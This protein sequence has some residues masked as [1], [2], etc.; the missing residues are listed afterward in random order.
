MGDSLKRAGLL[1]ILPILAA[2]AFGCES[3]S[4][5]KAERTSASMAAAGADARGPAGGYNVP[6]QTSAEVAA[7]LRATCEQAQKEGR[8]LLVEFSAP[9]CADC[10]ELAKM[11]E[12]SG[13][14]EKL[15]HT[16]H[17]VV[18]VGHFDRHE[19]LLKAY[20]IEAIANWQVVEAKDC[21]SPAGTWTKV[22]HRTLEPRSGSKI[23]SEELADWLTAQIP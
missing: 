15:A 5:W 2:G 3:L 13:L 1:L 14:K 19:E 16:P 20:G 6:E 10:R 9:W 18:N 8:R 17:F 22:A 21:G 7:G 12:Q 23:T 4:K 11:K